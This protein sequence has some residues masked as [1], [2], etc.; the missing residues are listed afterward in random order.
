MR[1]G[2]GDLGARSQGVWGQ[3]ATPRV[4]RAQAARTAGAPLLLP[5]GI[6]VQGV[7]PRAP[8]PA[9]ALPAA[10]RHHAEAARRRRRGS[11]E[12][13]HAR[14]ESPGRGQITDG[15]GGHKNGTPHR[16]SMSAMRAVRLPEAMCAMKA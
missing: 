14:P 6:D 1:R 16:V 10:E 7:A 11:Q 5:G 12:R 9:P 8:G 3:E 15:H 2:E 13:I 4:R